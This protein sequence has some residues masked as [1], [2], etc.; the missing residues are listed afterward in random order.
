M[1]WSVWISSCRDSFFYHLDS[2][3]THTHLYGNNLLVLCFVFIRSWKPFQIILL[4]WE[5]ALFSMLSI[6]GTKWLVQKM[7]S[8]SSFHKMYKHIM[9]IKEKN[10][11]RMRWWWRWSSLIPVV[12][13]ISSSS[14]SSL[15]SIDLSAKFNPLEW[16]QKYSTRLQLKMKISNGIKSK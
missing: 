1:I 10:Y 13:G 15:T 7:R 6:T 3:H 9:I 12:N 8:V 5:T 16:W 4:M 11:V 14:H 2:L